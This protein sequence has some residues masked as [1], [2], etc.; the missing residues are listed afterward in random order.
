MQVSVEAP[1]KLERR[2]TITVPEAVL[3][4]AYDKR[5]NQLTKTV[6]ANGYRPGKVPRTIIEKQYSHSARQEALSEVIQAS[7]NQ[8]INQ[9][10]LNPAG[11][12]TV[13]PKN[14]VPGQPLE[15]IATFEVIPTIDS[16][17]FEL[18]TL[19]KQMAVITEKDVENAFNRLCQQY[20]TWQV[21]DRPAQEKDQVVIDFRGSMEGKLFAGG[22]AHDYPI[23]LGSKSMIAGF[24]E[25]L[26]G[27]TVG[28]TKVLHLIFPENYHSTEMAGK[29]AEFAV[30]MK[31]ISQPQL[32]EVDE[33]F[34][35]KLGCKSGK[36]EDLNTEIRKN[37]ERELDRIIKAKLKGQVF[38]K[39]LEQNPVEVPQ[40][41]IEREGKRIH[42][43]LHPHHAGK[44]HGHS[45]AEMAVFNE[46]AKRNVSL[47]L[48]VAHL[49]KQ[50]QIE[51]NKERVTAYL[52]YLSS[53]YEDPAEVVAWYTKNK[54]A[55]SEIEM[56][57][58]E[59]Q[60]IEKL[61]EN[62]QLTEKMLSY[63]ELITGQSN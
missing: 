12:P 30:T 61:L 8:A 20:I 35:R 52:S 31:K 10:A 58:L 14:I 6:K 21:V 25:G 63:N 7:L 13:E 11:V 17:R 42:D 27:M 54:R 39:L 53:M 23:V 1:N 28:T 16:V 24:E 57:V 33:A 5:I 26:V 15:F 40:A 51:V 62:V 60:L 59:E 38:D 9:E 22:E 37:L 41:L 19:E 43:Q 46:P 29:S 45:A 48:L 18:A 55:M 47:G 44:D 56:Q 2:V 36:L 50:H 34:V 3:E 4:E 49:I 32:P